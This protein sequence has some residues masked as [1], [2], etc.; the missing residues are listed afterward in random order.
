MQNHLLRILIFIMIFS[1]LLIGSKANAQPLVETML[2]IRKSLVLIKALREEAKITSTP[3]VAID[4]KTGRIIVGQRI[5]E[6]SAV[7]NA[8]GVIISSD[9][10]IATNFH[11]IAMSHKIAVELFD[12]S[13]LA[14]EIIHMDPDDDLALLKINHSSALPAI[15]IADSDHVQLKDEILNVGSS[16]LLNGTISAGYVIG[17]GTM[18][19][20]IEQK[21][22]LEFIKVTI[23]LHKGDSGGPLLNRDGQL[24]GMVAARLR[25]NQ[26][27]S[28]IA[29]PSNKIKKLYL[30]S[31]K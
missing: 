7:T 4:Q 6:A 2:K 20:P 13:I 10:Y 24:L 15:E 23:R 3:S 22:V 31:T 16:Q 29:I 26:K 12:G 30:D 21:D 5:S 27:E 14:A 9:G 1:L 8:A 19:D 11:V 25:K 28:T 17:R 18:W